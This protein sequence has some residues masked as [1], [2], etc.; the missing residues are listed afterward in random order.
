[1]KSQQAEQKAAKPGKVWQPTQY[2]NLIRYVPSG[3]FF[4][5]LRVGGKLIRQSLKTDVLS[6]A[7][8]RLADLEKNERESV[9]TRDTASKGRMTFGDCVQ[10]FKTQTEDSKLLKPSAKL[11]RAEAVTS[12]LKSW[13][14]LE[15]LDVRKISA[16]D[17][18]SWAAKFSNQYSGTRFNGAV[19]VLR[20]VF[21]IA[22]E[23]GA[24]HRNPAEGIKRA[25][26]R[27]KRLTLPDGAQFDL[28]VKEIENANGRDS[29]KCAELVRFL[30]YGGFRI[31][32]ARNITWADCDFEKGEIVV[33]GDLETGTKNWSVRR[34]PMIPE[35]K[36]MLERLRAERAD[37]AASN[38]VMRVR[39]C[40]QA[41]KRA[42]KAVGMS[43][44]THH[45]LRHLFATLCI[46]SGV[47]IPTVSRW[48]GHKD[49]GALAMR[50]YGH[51]RD[52]HSV[53]MAQKVTFGKLVNETKKEN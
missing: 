17:C 49:G 32:E 12:I 47:D 52:Q 20:A 43:Q 24:L 45:D 39:E 51:L 2:S 1:M 6:I 14:E 44:I 27:S 46:E 48:L 35:M 41:M 53:A 50:V 29:S 4:A 25:K 16:S 13:P 40:I 15:S 8:L 34:V 22:N 26:V 3:T 10:I 42:A 23:C 31:S 28:F 37:E 18:N 21:K 7:K 38:P 19:G 36:T 33:R 30:A 5:R 11:Y 9:E